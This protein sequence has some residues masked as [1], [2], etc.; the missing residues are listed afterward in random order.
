MRDLMS[1]HNDKC[2]GKCLPKQPATYQMIY[3][4]IYH[5][6]FNMVNKI[7]IQYAAPYQWQSMTHYP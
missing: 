1:M 6:M 2:P 3:V 5:R 7:I 4:L